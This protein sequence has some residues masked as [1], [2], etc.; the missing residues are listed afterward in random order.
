MTGEHVEGCGC[1]VADGMV[2]TLDKRCVAIGGGPSVPWPETASVDV[3]LRMS[4]ELVEQLRTWSEPVQAR[5]VET[6]G[7]GTGWEMEL[8]RLELRRLGERTA[9][10]EDAQ[11][12]LDEGDAIVLHTLGCDSRCCVGVA[13]VVADGTGTYL[14]GTTKGHDGEHWL[15]EDLERA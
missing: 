8:R 4:P 2:V 13:Y 12:C 6:P 7:V 11:M 15:P 3:L 1:L 10:C 14:C 9:C 5:L